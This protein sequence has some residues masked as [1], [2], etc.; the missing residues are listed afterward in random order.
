MK[1]FTLLTMLVAL[2]SVT[3]FAQKGLRL[4]PMKDALQTSSVITK[5]IDRKAQPVTNRTRRAA[6]DELVTPPATA[7]VETWYLTDGKFYAYTST[8]WVDAT[9]YMPTIKVA[10]DGNDMYIQGLAYWMPEGWIKGE[11]DGFMVLFDNGQFV[12]E[13]ENGAEYMVGSNDGET[14]SDGIL[15][16]YSEEYGVLECV[17]DYLMENAKADEVSPYC[18]W[19]KPT[20]SKDEPVAP[21]VVVAPENLTVEEYTLTYNDYNDIPS[22]GIVK[23]G[24]DGNDV[25]VQGFNSYLPEAWIKGVLADGVVTFAGK[26]YYG[27]YNEQYEMF[28]QETDV[29]FVYDAEAES[30]T[31]EGDVYNYTGNMYAD[32]Y[33]NLVMTK[34]VEKAATPATPTISAVEEGNYGWYMTFKVP[35]VDTEGNGMLSSKLSYQ[36]FTD[37]E[38]EI[39]PLT[40]TPATHTR[41]TEDMTVIPYGF[42]ESWDFYDTQIYFNDLFSEDWNKIGIQST[43][44]GGGE[45]HKSE[46]YWFTLKEYSKVT[47]DF[48][49]MDVACS[50]NDSD[51]GDITEDYEITAGGVTLTVSPKSEEATTPNRFWST[52]YG[53]QLRVYSGTLTFTAPADKAI[54]KMVINYGKWNDGNSVDCGVISNVS[55]AK[56]ATWTGEAQK[57]VVSIAANT[58]LNSIVL[59]LADFVPTIVEAP[60]GLETETYIFKATAVVAKYDPEDEAPEPYSAQI[61]VGFDGDDVYI[62]GLASD[63]PELWVKATKNESGQ[64]VIPASQYMGV[65][66]VWGGMFTFDYYFTAVD[67]EGNLVDAVLDFDAEKSEFTTSQ[68]LMLNESPT[69]LEPYVTFT[70]VVIT[71]FIEVA[72]T[73]ADPEAQETGVLYDTYPYA[74]FS[75]PAVGTYGEALNLSKLFYT[76]WIEKDG[77]QQPYTFTAEAYYYDFT[78]DVLEVPYTYDGE[79]F[80]YGGEVVYFEEEIAEFQSW[81]KIGIQSIYYGCDERRASNVVWMN[82]SKTDGISTI[83]AD[84]KAGKAVIYNINGQRLEAP[85]K[86]LNIIN[87]RKVVIK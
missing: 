11:I 84:M 70:D 13:D 15:F 44:T 17:T 18:Y 24:I 37:V 31:A 21:E 47:I 63:A 42:T 35:V 78:E 10:I 4:L 12:G 81:T 51:A 59:E 32:Y 49:A 1:K 82:N 83:P 52:S 72:A 43:Y 77:V 53:P 80:Y 56:V 87:G 58:Q 50:T 67:E 26:Q 9:S 85:Q 41:L 54:T 2:F 74:Y 29:T 68:T 28:L 79:D 7:T 76:V 48:N 57:V 66:S 20:F 30:F 73:P 64:Y 71:K 6:S 14:L 75:V 5:A 22:S 62:Q 27:N 45:E 61:E 23:I 38:Q 33:V 34:V 86:G 3:A 55:T 8:G 25:Y 65:L 46:I 16:N 39:S 60:E 69:D 36:I 19:S 40:F